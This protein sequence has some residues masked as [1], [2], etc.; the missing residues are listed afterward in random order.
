LHVTNELFTPKKTWKY[1]P[2]L[3]G[4]HDKNKVIY[5]AL[6]DIQAAICLL[7]LSVTVL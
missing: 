6:N 3:R 1:E 2:R 4:S 7:S 5:L